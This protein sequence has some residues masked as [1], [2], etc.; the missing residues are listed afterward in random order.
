MDVAIAALTT[1]RENSGVF[2]IYMNDVLGLLIQALAYD[3]QRA[4][5]FAEGEMLRSSSQDH[6]EQAHL[7][8]WTPW[9]SLALTPNL[10]A[11][12]CEG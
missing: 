4:V 5:H 9:A 8:T 12:P 3:A 1:A 2:F 7:R 6:R 11:R 10:A